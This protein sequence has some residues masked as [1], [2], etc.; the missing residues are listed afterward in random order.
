MKKILLKK[1]FGEKNFQSKTFLVKK[2][3]LKKFVKKFLVKKIFSEKIFLSNKIPGQKKNLDKIVLG[4]T[5]IL[6]TKIFWLIKFFWPKK[7]LGKEK[8][9]KRIFH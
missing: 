7:N 9:V 2:F 8:S 5:K 4:H 6:V 1:I 3:Q